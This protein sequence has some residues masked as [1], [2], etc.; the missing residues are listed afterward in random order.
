MSVAVKLYPEAQNK[1]P[2]RMYVRIGYVVKE[3]LEEVNE[4]TQQEKVIDVRF[5]LDK[6]PKLSRTRVPH[7]NC[8]N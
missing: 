6:V 3:L 4:G 1:R 8:N 2:E 7:W 5:Q